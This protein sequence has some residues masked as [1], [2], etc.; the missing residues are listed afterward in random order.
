MLYALDKH[1]L[2][3]KPCNLLSL[4]EIFEL[5]KFFELITHIFHNINQTILK[6]PLICTTDSTYAF[7]NPTQSPTARPPTHSFIEETLFY[8]L[9]MKNIHIITLITLILICLP[10]AQA[11]T[12]SMAVSTSI[13][14][15]NSGKIT[16]STSSSYNLAVPLAWSPSTF[17][18]TYP[19]GLQGQ[20]SYT[21]IIGL[22][23]MRIVPSS[24]RTQFY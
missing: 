16:V 23:S 10:H 11:A 19:S 15:V 18:Y 9:L 3:A 5:I 14:Y 6:R 20:N 21:V 7:P 8:K 12:G 4:T 24:N 17:S 1:S 22:M 2:G 13:K